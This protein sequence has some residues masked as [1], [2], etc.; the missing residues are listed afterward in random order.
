MQRG[1]LFPIQLLLVYT[2]FGDDV[3][4]Q[5]I[6]WVVQ[7]PFARTISKPTLDL[8]MCYAEVGEGITEEVTLE[9]HLEG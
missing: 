3:M 6:I 4:G 8:T 7:R 1:S 2:S 5:I 9:Q